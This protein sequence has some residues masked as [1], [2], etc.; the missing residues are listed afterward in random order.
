MSHCFI[1][2]ST[3][4][5]LNDSIV[6]SQLHARNSGGRR[7][8]W[9]RD[10]CAG[11]RQRTQ[12]ELWRLSVVD[13]TARGI[14][15]RLVPAAGYPLQLVRVG[16]LKNVSLMTRAKTVFDLPRALWEAGRMLE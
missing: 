4:Q 7:D 9:A 2:D 6:Y 12:E 8:G 13:R 10:P 1:F 3:S 15:N 14:E 11:Y 5:W 16:G